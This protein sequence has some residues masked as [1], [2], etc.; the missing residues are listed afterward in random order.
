MFRLFSGRCKAEIGLAI[1]GNV[2]RLKFVDADLVLA[3]E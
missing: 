2:C 1:F 3:V